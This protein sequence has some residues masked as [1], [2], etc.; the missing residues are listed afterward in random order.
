MANTNWNSISCT[1][2]RPFTAGMQARIQIGAFPAV[3]FAGLLGYLV[4]LVVGFSRRR[5]RVS[6]PWD[7]E[8]GWRGKRLL[9]PRPPESKTGEQ[10]NAKSMKEPRRILETGSK[11]SMSKEAEIYQID[12]RRP[13]MERVHRNA[14]TSGAC[15]TRLRVL[16]EK[17]Q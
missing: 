13:Q 16:R 10:K 7:L 1:T 4:L 3:G 15:K 17:Q 9:R 11:R 5:T 12:N 8:T 14:K 6:V 2:N